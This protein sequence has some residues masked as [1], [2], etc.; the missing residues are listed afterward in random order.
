MCPTSL[1][2][3]CSRHLVQEVWSVAESNRDL[4]VKFSSV[5]LVSDLD[6]LTGATAPIEEALDDETVRDIAIVIA[7]G[8]LKPVSWV[9][10]GASLV[11][12]LRNACANG[13]LESLPLVP[14]GALG[15]VAEGPPMFPVWP[16]F[17]ANP[18]KAAAN[19]AVGR[20]WPG[21]GWAPVAAFKF[22][23]GRCSG[24]CGPPGGTGLFPANYR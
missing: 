5:F 9:S 22:T 10:P 19:P 4:L 2:C 16:A 8:I 14:R 18:P 20:S 7:I 17:A 12:A 1:S 6:K 23:G 11:I 24:A 13:L 3:R 21:N 15:A